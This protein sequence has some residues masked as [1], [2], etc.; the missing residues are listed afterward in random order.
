[1]NDMQEIIET[2]R[3]RL[4]DK[5]YSKDLKPTKKEIES[6]VNKTI[7]FLE[8]RIDVEQ[9]SEIVQNLFNDSNKE[10]S[11][12]EVITNE[13]SKP[14]IH[15]RANEEGVDQFSR[16]YRQHLLKQGKIPSVSI[17]EIFDES[18]YILD[19]LANPLSDSNFKK[20]GL[21]IGNVQSGKTANY[22]GLINRAADFGYKLIILL[23]G[24]HNN[25]R[26]QTQMRVNEGFVGYDPLL[27]KKMGVGLLEGYRN[28][29]Q[30]VSFT[31]CESDFDKHLSQTINFNP[32]ISNS[33]V[34][35]VLKKNYHTLNS[36][37][38][39]LEVDSDR[40][41]YRNSYPL[42]LID[43]EADNASVNYKDENDSPTTI[44]GQ[45]RQILGLFDKSAYVGYTATPF[46]NIFINPNSSDNFEHDDL[47]P[48][49]FIVS[50]N[51]P[52]NY[53]GPKQFFLDDS[54]QYISKVLDNEQCIP[55]KPDRDWSIQCIPNTLKRAIEHFLLTIAIKECRNTSQ[56]HTSMLINI[57]H[58]VSLQTETYEIVS[59][60]LDS[61]KRV[62]RFEYLKGYEYLKNKK[63]LKHLHDIWVND[64][65]EEGDFVDLLTT[66]VSKDRSIKTYLINS[67]STDELD[68][69]LYP[70]GLHV[71][72]IGG[73]SLSRGFTLEGLTT[74]YILRN[75]KMSD[76]ILQMGRWFGY[77]DGYADICRIFITPKSF[78]WYSHIAEV[79]EELKNEIKILRRHKL[80]PKEYGLKIRNHPGALEITAKNK[81]RSGQSVVVSADFSAT[82]FQ[83]S[84]L[85]AKTNT[86]HKNTETLN[87]W[88]KSLGDFEKIDSGYLWK[89]IS[90]KSVSQFTSDFEMHDSYIG[91]KLVGDYI[92]SGKIEELESWDVYLPDAGEEQEYSINSN[93]L[94]KKQ[95]RTFTSIEGNIISFEGGGGR[96]V[97]FFDEE[98]GLSKEELEWAKEA[99]NQAGVKE[100]ARYYR[101]YRSKP[102]LVLKLFT[103]KLKSGEVVA[104]VIP[105]FGISFPKNKKHRSVEY[106]VN[107]TWIKNNF[108]E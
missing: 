77:R 81:M 87:N 62:I 106:T 102:L 55:V 11:G 8:K 49:D 4:F 95:R 92:K 68:Y 39:W 82:L 50:L 85:S 16:L 96:V 52:P 44:N 66:I 32:N 69:D 29:P 74:S 57:S 54:E 26:R 47:F 24:I 71:I 5:F 53:V 97:R 19:L 12:Y 31:N 42:L 30:P 61:I 99:Q 14:W 63:E 46:A 15:T 51:P 10:T 78:V 105:A 101:E 75:S 7:E 38:N 23:S 83:S 76:T 22:L 48:E 65:N 86:I 34:I 60:Y 103:V 41:V 36:V 104:D 28:I 56:V 3:V 67:E 25:L 90:N 17:H 2:V 18:D 98:V 43:D 91:G 9:K 73:Y 84:V 27:K 94:V 58:K 1:M 37:I 70:Q 6:W 45:I 80:T 93:I 88:I 72:A 59:E 64:F 89:N 13:K 79:I 108:E 40:G 20:K 107:K 33:P 35:L 100:T 21:V